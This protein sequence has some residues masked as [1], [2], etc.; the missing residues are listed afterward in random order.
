MPELNGVAQQLA[1]P[2]LPHHTMVEHGV[3]RDWDLNPPKLMAVELHLCVQ[4]FIPSARESTNK[5]KINLDCGRVQNIGLL[6]LLSLFLVS[7][8]K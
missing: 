8:P 2:G 1:L 3:Q 6:A 4:C 7:F 5:D